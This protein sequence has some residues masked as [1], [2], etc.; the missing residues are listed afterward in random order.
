MLLMLD[1]ECDIDSNF[2]CE[3]NEVYSRKLSNF[4]EF[5]G[6]TIS[7]LESLFVFYEGRIKLLLV[8]TG[9]LLNLGFSK[10]IL[11][12]LDLTFFANSSALAS[13]IYSN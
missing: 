11:S 5:L 3:G 1:F 13:L 10:L 9:P 4:S 2:F 12:I 7:L 8:S 6:E